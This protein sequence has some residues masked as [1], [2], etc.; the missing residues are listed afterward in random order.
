MDAKLNSKTFVK[1]VSR[2][3]GDVSCANGLEFF[4][5]CKYYEPQIFRGTLLIRHAHEFKLKEWDVLSFY[6]F[7]SPLNKISSFSFWVFASYF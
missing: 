6:T 2:F 3:F 5:K 1:Y 4:K 7:K